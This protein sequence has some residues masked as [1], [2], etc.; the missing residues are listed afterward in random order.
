VFLDAVQRI[1][2]EGLGAVAELGGAPKDSSRV[3]FLNGLGESS[4]DWDVVLQTGNRWYER[5][6]QA[7]RVDDPR[8]RRRALP[9]FNNDLHELSAGATS[10][11]GF[12]WDFFTSERRRI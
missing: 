11:K 9:A 10:L 6:S 12:V 8:E 2:Q 3:K 5:V 7:S 4:V 1:S